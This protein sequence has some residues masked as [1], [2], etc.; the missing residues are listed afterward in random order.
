MSGLSDTGIPRHR[1]PAPVEII[2]FFH[3][4]PSL[5]K[6]SLASEDQERE[7]EIR[8]RGSALKNRRF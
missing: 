8:E 6:V 2:R 1:V 4:L 3:P 5:R 7:R